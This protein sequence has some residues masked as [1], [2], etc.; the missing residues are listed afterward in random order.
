MT[1]VFSGA[2][3][4]GISVSKIGGRFLLNNWQSQVF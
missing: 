2:S 1:P 3:G 4:L